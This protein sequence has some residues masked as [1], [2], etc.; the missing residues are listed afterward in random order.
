MQEDEVWEFCCTSFAANLSIL[1]LKILGGGEHAP[2]PSKTV[3]DTLKNLIVVWKSQ[4][5]SFLP[6]TGHPALI[7]EEL[8][9]ASSFFLYG[10]DLLVK[11]IFVVHCYTSF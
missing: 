6:E 1:I 2:R 10:K 4:E 9:L 3:L 5:I 11:G 8:T 7:S